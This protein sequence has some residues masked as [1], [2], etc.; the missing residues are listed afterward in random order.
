V[1]SIGRPD[2]AGRRGGGRLLAPEPA[3]A[4]LWL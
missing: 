4:S 2:S 3:F 1:I